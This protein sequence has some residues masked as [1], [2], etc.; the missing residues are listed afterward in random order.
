M[1][2]RGIP[3]LGTIDSQ[4]FIS[5]M[6]A[7]R[8][9]ERPAGADGFSQRPEGGRCAD[10]WRGD[11][12]GEW[13]PIRGSRGARAFATMRS[14][15]SPCHDLGWL[16][17]MATGPASGTACPRPYGMALPWVCQGLQKS[18]RR[19]SSRRHLST[20]NRNCASPDS[21]A[22][23]GE[24]LRSRRRQMGFS[25]GQTRFGQPASQPMP[26]CETLRGCFI[27]SSQS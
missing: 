24:R 5:S 3:T 15:S 19:R 26:C 20:T 10:P 6:E 17:G 8:R 27:R 23:R 12:I 1:A 14:A 9:W 7:T 13:V 16:D 25:A 4:A 18:P 21:P 2:K 11:A 22:Q